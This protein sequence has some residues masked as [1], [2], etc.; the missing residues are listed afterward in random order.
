MEPNQTHWTEIEIYIPIKA[1]TLIWTKLHCVLPQ[2]FPHPFTCFCYGPCCSFVGVVLFLYQPI[3]YWSRWAAGEYQIHHYWCILSHLG[4]WKPSFLCLLSEIRRYLIRR[5]TA[6]FSRAVAIDFITLASCQPQRSSAYL[7]SEIE[8]IYLELRLTGEGDLARRI[9]FLVVFCLLTMQ[10]S[11][12][13]VWT[14]RLIGRC[15]SFQS[16]LQMH[17]INIHA[18]FSCSV[19]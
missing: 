17:E 10:R 6:K 14:G 11:S 12:C 16:W 13:G 3:G 7:D 15:C 18:F 5:A 19:F 4:L 8:S 2:P 1:I 9:S